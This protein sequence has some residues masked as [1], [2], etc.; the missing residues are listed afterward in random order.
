MRK[1]QKKFLFHVELISIC[2]IRWYTPK[3]ATGYL[4]QNRSIS[5]SKL[6]EIHN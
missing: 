4:S 6:S 2:Y 3:V 5:V 1:L